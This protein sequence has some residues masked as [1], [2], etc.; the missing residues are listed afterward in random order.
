MDE[1]QGRCKIIVV[2]SGSIEAE[3]H[4]LLDSASKSGVNGTI[5]HAGVLRAV[6]G[7]AGA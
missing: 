1:Y 5:Q 7:H 2:D 6:D 3:T 4:A